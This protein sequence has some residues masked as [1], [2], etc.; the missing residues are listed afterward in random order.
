MWRGPYEE[1]DLPRKAKFRFHPE[2]KKW[3]TP[4]P[5]VAAR[6]REICDDTA[7][8]QINRKVLHIEPWT[9]ELPIPPGKGLLPFQK[10]A[11]VFALARNRS[12]LAL[13]PGLGKTIIAVVTM[14]ALQKRYG[15]YSFVYFTPPFLCGNVL[16]E[17]EQWRTFDTSICVLDRLYQSGDTRLLVVPDSLLPNESKVGEVKNYLSEETARGRKIG[18]LVDEAHR[19]NNQDS[20]RSRALLGFESAD[21]DTGKIT[22]VSGL[23]DFHDRVTYLSGTPMP[24]RPIELFPILSHSAPD[25]IGDMNRFD[26]GVRYCAGHDTGFGWDFNG[27][28]HIPELVAKIQPRFMLRMRKDFLKL[29]P[30]LEGMIVLDYDMGPRLA[31]LD[32]KLLEKYSPEDLIEEELQARAVESGDLEEDESLHTS[33]YKRLLGEHKVRAAADLITSLLTESSISILVGGMHTAAILGLAALLKGFDPFVV[34]GGVPHEE[35]F[36]MVREFQS[37]KTRRL[38]IANIKAFGLGFTL[39]KAELALLF[40]FSWNPADNDQFIDRLHRIGQTKTVLARYLV[41]RNS[42]DKKVLE[43]NLRKR[44]TTEQV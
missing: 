34:T 9:G 42:L 7:L 10:R 38:F 29:P 12:Y 22:P 40:E 13:D 43:L 37:S 8:K 5:T 16:A 2:K 31:E 4:S 15:D 28:S 3:Y 25:T 23:L 41:F 33:T 26:Y 18:F 11:A 14:N 39:T 27:A 20:K 30:R 21:K 17:F 1:R 36:A 6:L 35:R 24:N 32:K 19:F 44:E